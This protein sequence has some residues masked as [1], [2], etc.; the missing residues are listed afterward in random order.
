MRKELLELIKSTIIYKFDLPNSNINVSKSLFS[1]ENDKCYFAS[2]DFDLSEIIYN[3][4]I[5]YS[6][7]NYDINENDYDNLH[8]IALKT[9]LRYKD[10]AT[11]TQ[12]ISYGFHGE[13]I[14]YSI[15]FA[16]YNSAPAI[17]RGYFYNPLESSETKGY[18]SYHLIENGGQTELWFGEVKFRETHSS[19]IKSALDTLDKAISDEYLA[20]NFLAI[21]NFKNSFNIHG[22][23]IETI[24]KDW[25]KNPSVDIIEEIK[26][27]DI[28]LVYPIVILSNK[29]SYG[30]DKS[31]ENAIKYIEDRYSSKKY[32][33]SIPYSIYF[34]WLPVD[35]VRDIKTKVIEWI[36]SKKQLMS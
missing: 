17:S 32:N 26:K 20:N 12:K 15:L 7:N 13:T 10:S 18:D 9:K 36:E 1:T 11:E 19:G 25:E 24:I 22:T 3:S 34:F 31:I 29:S 27:H 14:L 33:I 35:N 23:K 28:K 2:S 30:Y 6:F 8:S 5:E 21:T 16:I 4:I